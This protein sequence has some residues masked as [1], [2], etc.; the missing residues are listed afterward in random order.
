MKKI[1]LLSLSVFA[2][3]F[4]QAQDLDLDIDSEESS[5]AYK[6]S[7]GDKNLELQ[8]NP[9][10]IFA[11]GGNV[12]SNPF[13]VSFR[14]FN[15]ASSAIRVK[16]NINYTNSTTLMQEADAAL[17]MA[18]LTDHYSGLSISLRPG[19]EKHFAGTERLSPY[20]GAEAVISFS[21]NTDKAE[22][23]DFTVLPTVTVYEQTVK[24]DGLSF[25]VAGVAGADFYIAKKLYLGVELN[26]GIYY[27]LATT[28]KVSDTNPSIDD[29]ESKVGS[30]NTLSFRPGTMGLF[31]I[32]YLF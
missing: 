25:G 20:V 30:P 7:S 4:A 32:G 29:V 17:N 2:F 23:Q 27:S 26:Y 6:Q 10:A 19:I 1:I 8:F 16:A 14:M 11:T 18:E 12:F 3:A 9:G 15:S 5:S 31:K 21:T 28:V 13:G 24:D 22:Y